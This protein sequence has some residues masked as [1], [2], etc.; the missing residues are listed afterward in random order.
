MRRIIQPFD[1]VERVLCD[2]IAYFTEIARGEA[3]PSKIGDMLAVT[4][5]GLAI[6]GLVADL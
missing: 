2:R 6:F 5:F 1:I 4:V 3:L